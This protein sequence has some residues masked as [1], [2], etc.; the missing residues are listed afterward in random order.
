M[1]IHHLITEYTER[2]KENNKIQME[3]F[4]IIIFI[5][6]IYLLLQDDNDKE[7]RHPI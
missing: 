5:H 3:I 7:H 4:I 6:Q 2:K 1:S